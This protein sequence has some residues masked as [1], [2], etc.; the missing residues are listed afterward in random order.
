MTLTQ[1]RYL[2]AIVD[3]GFNISR[4]A[5]ALHTSQPGMSRQ[6]RLLEEQLGA[7]VLARQQGRIVG[8]TDSGMQAV[9]TARRILK[10]VGSLQSMGAD[11]LRQDEGRLT[12]G[13]LH[14]FAMSML[15]RALSTLRASYPR[16]IFDV[17]QTSPQ[18]TFDLV[19][20]GELDV[21]VTITPPEAGRD[22]LALRIGEV[23]LV[24][25]VPVGHELI[26]RPP[27][28]LADLHGY[29]IIRLS[30]SASAWGVENAY[31]SF[32]LELNTALHVMD[33]SVMISHV[34]AG[35]GIA[36]V[37]ALI[38]LG[39]GVTAIDVD[40]L[41]SPNGIVAAI[42]PNRFHRRFVYEFIELIA[43]QWTKR[44]I[45]RAIRDAVFAMPSAEIR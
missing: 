8:M 27:R 3:H 41:V 14:T 38:P 31:K 7:R 6:I 42:D 43:P 36:F 40:H 35:A 32:G 34:A 30:P 26:D 25:V 17:R 19:A 44:R 37:P 33:A 45:D 12:C 29:P 22:L 16:V 2:V 15:P 4:A 11:I 23:K 20:A 21:G 1:L 5:E 24:L 18:S 10:D 9:S 28:T 13:T 39:S